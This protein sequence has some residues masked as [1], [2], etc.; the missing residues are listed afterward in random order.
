MRH[1]LI[2]MAIIWVFLTPLQNVLA[3]D[4]N[5][6]CKSGW[7]NSFVV[8][9]KGDV[10]FV[11]GLKYPDYTE[12]VNDVGSLW[13]KVRVAKLNGHEI[14]LLMATKNVRTDYIEKIEFIKINIRNLTFIEGVDKNRR[15]RLAESIADWTRS[16]SGDCNIM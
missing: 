7:F 1:N 3:K 6:T 10:F 12:K 16:S 11:D 14:E 15:K 5:L 2:K 8:V 4:L 13:A 9:Q